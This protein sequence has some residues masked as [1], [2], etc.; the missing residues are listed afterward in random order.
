MSSIIRLLLLAT[1]FAQCAEAEACPA[2]DRVGLGI[3]ATSVEH[4]DERVEV[5]GTLY[6]RGY[7]D[8]R[9]R[10]LQQ[11]PDQWGYYVGIFVLDPDGS[12]GDER[13]SVCIVG[14]HR[15]RDGLTTK[16]VIALGRGTTHI[17]DATVSL[18]DYVFYPDETCQADAPARG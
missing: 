17:A 6:G 18:P 1:V 13:A 4:A 16:E 3:L 9:E 14:T 15:R 2:A 8:P 11:G 5:C 10:I 7:R 12:L